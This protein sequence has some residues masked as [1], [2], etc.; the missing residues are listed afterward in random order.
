[1]KA[2][3]CYRIPVLALVILL[4][5]CL[6]INAQSYIPEM[7]KA[8]VDRTGKVMLESGPLIYDNV[9]D[10]SALD[11]TVRANAKAH[12]SGMNTQLVT[13]EIDEAK[14]EAHVQIELRARPD[15]TVEDWNKYLSSL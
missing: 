4:S 1:M 9:F 5:I 2:S 12:F 8:K 15:W 14:G 6:D 3:K 10:L 7:G 13:F 11:A